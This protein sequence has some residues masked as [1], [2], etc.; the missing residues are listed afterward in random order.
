MQCNADHCQHAQRANLTPCSAKPWAWFL[1]LR[2]AASEITAKQMVFHY[3]VLA[4]KVQKT[5]ALLHLHFV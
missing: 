5:Y 3:E 1:A 4:E 2:Q